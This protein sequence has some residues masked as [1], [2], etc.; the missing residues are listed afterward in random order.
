MSTPSVI[1]RPVHREDATDLQENCFSRNT[2]E[3]VHQDH[4]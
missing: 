3:E 1:I 2:L 4:A